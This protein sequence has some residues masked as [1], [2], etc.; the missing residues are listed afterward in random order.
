MLQKIPKTQQFK[1]QVCTDTSIPW[2]SFPQ[3]SI[4]PLIPPPPLMP[5]KFQSLSLSLSFP[6]IQ[7]VSYMPTICSAAPRDP[8]PSSSSHW[9]SLDMSFLLSSVHESFL[10]TPRHS[11][12]V[13]QETKCWVIIGFQ[14]HLCLRGWVP[15][16]LAI[17]SFWT[18]LL[19]AP[20]QALPKRIMSFS[21]LMYFL[22]STLLLS[23]FKYS[24]TCLQ[25]KKNRQHIL[26]LPSP[27]DTIKT[28]FER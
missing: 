21:I 22:T 2:V 28:F 11:V 4:A 12:L 27:D 6:F 3:Q 15:S 10:L 8:V 9:I 7:G 18:V 17:W 13:I 26:L 23:E 24:V 20:P 1:A 25:L 19:P 16:T 5:Q 14:P